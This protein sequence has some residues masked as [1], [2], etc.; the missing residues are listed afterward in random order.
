MVGGDRGH[1][2]D[3]HGQRSFLLVLQTT[4]EEEG[5]GPV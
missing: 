4:L 5:D 2:K 1:L 3:E